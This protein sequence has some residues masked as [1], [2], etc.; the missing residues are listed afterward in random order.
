MDS[1]KFRKDGSLKAVPAVDSL[2]LKMKDKQNESF[3]ESDHEATH[4]K[5]VNT[6]WNN[7]YSAPK[8]LWIILICKLFES[9]SFISEDFTFMLFFS[10]EFGMTDIECGLVYSLG[11]ILTFIYGL[12][13]SGYLIDNAGVKPCLLIG[14]LLLSITR[15]SCCFITS[16]RD[17]Y[18]IFT[19]IVPIGLSMC[20][21]ILLPY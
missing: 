4:I 21:Q 19:T 12:F 13:F 5:D 20:N 1:R 9:F 11:A 10:E 7:L 18:L 16:K 15:L 6:T 8:E 14:S 3:E 17:L 2:G